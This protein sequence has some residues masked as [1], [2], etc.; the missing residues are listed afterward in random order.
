MS[1]QP[2]GQCLTGRSLSP[3]LAQ[4]ITFVYRDVAALPSEHY[5]IEASEVEGELE[6]L[7]NAMVRIGADLT[8]LTSRV[9]KEMDAKL[10]GIFEAHRMMLNDA[11]LKEELCKEIRTEMVSAGSA[12]RTVFRRWERRFRAMEAEIARQK[13]DDVVD[14]GRR[15]LYSL[16]GIHAHALEKLPLGS[17]LVAKRLL[18]SDTFFLGRRSAAAAILESG[19]SSSHAALFA[20]EIGLPCVTGIQ[21]ATNVVRAGVMALVDADSGEVTIDPSAEQATNFERKLSAHRETGAKARERARERAVTRDGVEITVLANVGCREDTVDAMENGAEGIGLYRIEQIYLMRQ[22]PPLVDELVAE[23]RRTVE[24]AGKAP[25]CVRLLDVGADKQLPYLKSMKESNP[26]LGRRGI[27]FLRYFP[28]LLQTQIE[29]LLRLSAEFDLRVLVPMVTVPD[30]I[31][32]V[33][34]VMTEIASRYQLS[35]LPK[36]GALIET[37]AAAL[38][39]SDLASA[40]DFF[41]VGTNDLTQYA[42]AADRENTAVD[43]YFNDAH[44]VVFRLIKA[45]RDDASETPLAVC[46]ELAG[47]HQ[48]VERLLQCGVR[49]LSVAPHLVP[50]VKQAVRESNCGIEVKHEH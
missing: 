2:N 44:E 22:T 38:S 25:V 3:G 39:A 19:G 42:F 4:G 47:R 11:A 34:S 49:S 8:T 12:V 9:E 29:A 28:D 7:E 30:D 43:A 32:A 26:S 17:V 15:L 35:A 33:R 23:I 40:S 36:L 45:I 41:S 46:G 50:T 14:L 21:N 37:P 10:A 20:R 18:P 1:E 48:H 24:P 31:A 16:A 13:G 6:R 27:R 5:D